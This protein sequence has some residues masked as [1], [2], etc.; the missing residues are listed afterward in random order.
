MSTV[1][2]L[3]DVASRS[4]APRRLGNSEADIPTRVLARSEVLFAAGDI[5]TN[6]YRIESGV[7]C[8]FRKRWDGREEIV[9]FAFAGDLVGMGFLEQHAWSARAT[10]DTVVSCLPLHAADAIG[11]EDVRARARRKEAIEREFVSRRE[12]LVSAGRGRPMARLA[13]FLVVLSRRNGVEGRDPLVIDEFL[14]C[15]VVA[16]YLAFSADSLALAIVQ[17]GKRGLVQATSNR[18]LRINDVEALQSLASEGSG[19]GR[20]ADTDCVALQ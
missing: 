12:V 16:D 8:I 5:K 14:D 1:A 7:L 17:L 6:L 10:V 13:A 19:S 4:S 20:H 11:D 9:E 3:A 18:G 15:A 2:T